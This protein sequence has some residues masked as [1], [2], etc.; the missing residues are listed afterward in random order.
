VFHGGGKTQ[1]TN[2]DFTRVGV[3]E[4]IVALDVSVDDW[5][6]L[7][8]QVGKAFEHFVTPLF[9]HLQFG[10][11]HLFQILAQRAAC[12]DLGNKVNLFFFLANPSGDEGDDVRVVQLFYQFYFRLYPW[13]F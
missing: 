8:V 1:V 2:L 10:L 11:A 6:L 7:A 12:N 9:D 3:D 5:H 4:D 13:S